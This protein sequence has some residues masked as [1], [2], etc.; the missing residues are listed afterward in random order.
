VVSV[1]KAR[2]ELGRV[3]VVVTGRVSIGAF[4]VL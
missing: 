4:M 2:R 3:C 1:R